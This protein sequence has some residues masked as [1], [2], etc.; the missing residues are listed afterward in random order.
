MVADR[1]IGKTIIKVRNTGNLIDDPTLALP[2][3][4][5]R[6]DRSYIILGGLGGLGLELGRICV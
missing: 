4:Y 3:Y 5:C 2:R 1:H 6:S